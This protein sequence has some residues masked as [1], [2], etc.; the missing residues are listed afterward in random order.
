MHVE[1]LQVMLEGTTL[2]LQRRA[3]G[4][5]LSMGVLGGPLKKG[6]GVSCNEDNSG[7][8]RSLLTEE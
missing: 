4:W 2:H 5:A 1:L 3:L 8:P 7:L 6:G